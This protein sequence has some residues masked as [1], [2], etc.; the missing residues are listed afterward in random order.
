VVWDS[1]YGTAAGGNEDRR[2]QSPLVEIAGKTGTAQVRD[3]KT[4]QYQPLQHRVSFVGFFPYDDPQY[5]C[6]CVIQSSPAIDYSAPGDCGSTVRKIAEKAMAYSGT[7]SS[8][9]LSM[10]YDS[11]TKPGIKGGVQKRITEAAKGSGVQVTQTDSQWA[12][13]NQQMQAVDV[14][15][16]PTSVPN[17]IGMGARDAVYAIEQTGM[18]AHIQGKGKV[19]SQSVAPGSGIV[20]NGTIYLELR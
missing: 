9:E 19:A 16:Q 2:V 10:P 14:D 13:V 5:T 3:P 18:F 8:S 15:V 11:I 1:H 20:K 4:N 12:K 6:I 17:V 7:R